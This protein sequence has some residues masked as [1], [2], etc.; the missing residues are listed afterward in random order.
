MEW[1]KS[2]KTIALIALASLLLLTSCSSVQPPTPTLAIFIPAT[3]SPTPSPTTPA[4]I[5]ATHLPTNTPP[6]PTEIPE[7]KTSDVDGMIQLL[8]PMGNFEMGSENG[9]PDEV[10]VHTVKLA[11][12]WM[13]KFEVTYAQF[14]LFIQQENYQAAPCGYGNVAVSCVD[15][16]DAKAYCEWAG[17]R[18]P[19][20]AEW[21]K[22]A[23]GGSDNSKFPWGNGEPNCE[24]NGGEPLGDTFILTGHANFNWMN[25]GCINRPVVV[26]EFRPNGYGLFDMAGNVWEWVDDWYGFYPYG[27][28]SNPVG[29]PLGENK[30]IRGGSWVYGSYYLRNASRSRTD[31]YSVTNDIGFRCAE[32]V[33]LGR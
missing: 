20:E 15:W 12:F 28:Q 1:E 3:P 14:A 33:P 16:Y 10:P 13:D 27:T 11:G 24:N 22:A 9:D 2:M 6:Q 7:L 23:R 31:P 30:V 26:G 17:R 8:V 29:P 25:R 18:L 4:I 32:S 19:T 21:E 5:P